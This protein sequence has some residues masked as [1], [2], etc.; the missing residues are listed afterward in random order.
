MKKQILDREK[1]LAIIKAN[2]KPSKDTLNEDLT[3]KS[4]VYL[5]EV[6]EHLKI[7]PIFKS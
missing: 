4:D 1:T 5:M 7:E 2:K 6:C 3:K